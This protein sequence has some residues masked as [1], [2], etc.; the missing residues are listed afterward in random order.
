MAIDEASYGQWYHVM[1]K[2][3]YQN[4]GMTTLCAWER[5][6][7]Q[8]VD[9]TS[10]WDLYKYYEMYHNGHL[11]PPYTT[12]CYSNGVYLPGMLFNSLIL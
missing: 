7:Q 12:Q 8:K 9:A 4:S 1:N 6:D 10:I 5:S 11:M 3:T 2:T